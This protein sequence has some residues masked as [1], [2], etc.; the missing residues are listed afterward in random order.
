ME[1]WVFYAL[2]AALLIGTRDIFTSS[3]AKKYNS[4]QHLLNYY[5]LCGIIIFLY[6]AYRK[7]VHKENN[8]KLVETQDIWKYIFLAFISVIIISPCIYEALK[9]SD[10]PGKAKA[11]VNLN[12]VVAFFISYLF[13]RSVKIDMKSITGI[14]LIIIGIYLIV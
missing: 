4:T 3:F 6:C 8:F 1:N 7:N 5:I 14:L 11:V 12:T 9:L 10:N 2:I 13:L